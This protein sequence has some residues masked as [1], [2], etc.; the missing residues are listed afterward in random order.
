MTC[1]DQAEE[2]K[3][4]DQKVLPIPL[5]NWKNSIEQLFL[6]LKKQPFSNPWI[7]TGQRALAGALIRGCTPER[8]IDSRM[9]A[10]PY[11]IIPSSEHS[12]HRALHA[13]GFANASQEV[14]FCILGQAALANGSFFSACNLLQLQPSKVVFVILEQEISKEAPIAKQSQY[15]ISKLA[16]LFDLGYTSIQQN[17]IDDILEEV[18]RNLWTNV[19]EKKSQILHIILS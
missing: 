9:G 17:V 16:S 11:K 2:Q 12:G 18:L 15:D 3:L 1:I 13:V 5:G 19:M 6:I 10:R 4:L 8:L 7:F 14:V